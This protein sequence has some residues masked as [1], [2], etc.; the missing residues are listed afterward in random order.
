M[1][2]YKVVWLVLGFSLLLTVSCTSRKSLN[3]DNI[4]DVDSIAITDSMRPDSLHHPSPDEFM[5]GH[6]PPPPP[7]DGKHFDGP[8][9]PPPHGKGRPPHK[10]D[11][12]RGFDPASEDDMEDNGMGRY[13][14]NND[15]EGWD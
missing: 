9:P 12:M 13:M 10:P 15:E 1:M 3:P 7:P 14:E 5:D 4:S 8:P 11:N 6:T 2:K